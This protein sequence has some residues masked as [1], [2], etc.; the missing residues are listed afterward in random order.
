[1]SDDSVVREGICAWC[2]QKIPVRA[3]GPYWA[4][5]QHTRRRFQEKVDERCPGSGSHT[6]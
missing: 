2:G 5:V 6:G 3:D 1:M 4:F